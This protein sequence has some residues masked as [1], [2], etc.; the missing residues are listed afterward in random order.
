MYRDLG[1]E[2]APRGAQVVRWGFALSTTSEELGDHFGPSG[3]VV[4]ANV[5]TDRFSGQSRGF[6]FV[7]VHTGQ[8]AIGDR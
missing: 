8:G 5:L 1:V 3:T 2:G 6:G 4:S 7:D